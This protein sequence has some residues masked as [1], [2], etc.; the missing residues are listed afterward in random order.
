MKLD[1]II[2]D[3]LSPRPLELSLGDGPSMDEMME[4][5]RRRPNWKV[6]EQ[7]GPSAEVLKL[8][9]PEFIQA[10]PASFSMF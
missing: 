4:A 2:T 1:S 10:F 3:L 9:H 8:E 7:D 5:L 6:A